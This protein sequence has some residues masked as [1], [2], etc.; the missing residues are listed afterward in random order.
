MAEERMAKIEGFPPRLHNELI[1][2]IL[3]HH[4]ELE[5]GSPK[6]P[7]LIEAMILSFA[8]NMDAKV[9]TMYEALSSKAPQN[10]SGFIGFNKLIDSNLRRTDG[11][12]Y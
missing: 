10:E 12:Q 9:E 5:F 2:M 8:D 3:S 11:A 7:A 4:G 6:K 1:H